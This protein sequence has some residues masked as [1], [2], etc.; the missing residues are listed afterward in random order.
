MFEVST[1]L[2]DNSAELVF[3]G[4]NGFVNVSLLNS[5]A[6]TF[7][8]TFLELIGEF[9]TSMFGEV[10]ISTCMTFGENTRDLGS[11]GEEMNKTTTSTPFI[12]KKC[13]YRVWRR[14]R[15]LQATTSGFS[16]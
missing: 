13:A 8:S 4:G 1:I 6:S 14:R 3:G 16:K 7:C 10:L 5:A 9:A 15:R 11:F 12:L 2:E